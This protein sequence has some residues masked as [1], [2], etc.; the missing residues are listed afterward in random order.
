VSLLYVIRHGQASF[1]KGD[2]DRLSDL[3]KE[4]ARILGSY[5]NGQAISFDAAYCGAMQRQQDTAGLALAG[6]DSPPELTVL[7]QIN[8]Y[9]S[10][11]IMEALLPG[12]VEDEPGLGKLVPKLRSDRRAFQALYEATMLRWISGRYEVGFAETWQG[13]HERLAKGI[14]QVR[15]E[16]GRGRTAALF[17]SGGPISGV[18]KLA[19]DL[20][21]EVALRLTWVIRNASVSSFYYDH[22]R[23]TL[24]QFN[25]TGHLERA[26]DPELIT[27]R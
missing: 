1:G 15:A 19:L 7:P 23:L 18:M 16:N 12:L 10:E 26:G 14:A 9:D 11:A 22:E 6:M 3:G 17:T 25:R 4:Q 5:L 8:E 24:S 27:Y 21:D 2:Y 13:F 20:S